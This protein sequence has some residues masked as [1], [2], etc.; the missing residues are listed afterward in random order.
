MAV[1][2]L[3]TDA[4]GTVVSA[5]LAD[6]TVVPIERVAIRDGDAA[7]LLRSPSKGEISLAECLDQLAVRAVL[8]P[9][10]PTRAKDLP[11]A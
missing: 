10:G 1:K 9:G 7:R 6:G 8:L 4:T 5:T 2:R 3:N 11:R